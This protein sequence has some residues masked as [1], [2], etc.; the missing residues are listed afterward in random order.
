MK[1][2]A[3]EKNVSSGRTFR[4]IPDVTGNF[5]FDG[6]FHVYEVVTFKVI[7]VDCPLCAIVFVCDDEKTVN[8]IDVHLDLDYGSYKS[9]APAR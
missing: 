1:H 9:A 5:K 8:N 2:S 6:G 3:V 7:I 4:A